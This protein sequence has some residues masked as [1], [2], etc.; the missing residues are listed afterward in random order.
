MPLDG[1][2]IHSQARKAI[3]N[4]W[5]YSDI[6]FH[7]ARSPYWQAM[8]DAVAIAGPGFKAPTSESLR[9]NLL[10]ESVEDVMLVLA[11]FRSSWVET[12]C[13]I[14]SD[15]WTDQRNRTLI[16]FL[17]SC[18][19]DTMFLKSMDASDKVN[20]AQ[21]ICEMMEEVIQ[22]VGEEHVVQI[23]TDN[24]ANYMAVGRLF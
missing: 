4:F 22:E 11:E 2:N 6:P 14:I 13:T 3:A 12:R 19:V 18:P 21:L 17:V 1:K 20:I 15:G 24:A 7:C 8:I 5:Y 16:N 9:T 10:L 23:V